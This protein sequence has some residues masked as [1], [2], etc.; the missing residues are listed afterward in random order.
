M[1]SPS[2]C[3]RKSTWAGFRGGASVALCAETHLE[4]VAVPDVC[5]VVRGNAPRMGRG[6]RRFWRCARKRTSAGSRG[7]TFVAV[8]GETSAHSRTAE[9]TRELSSAEVPE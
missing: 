6:A 1:T 9:R 2:C 3:A 7:G 4:W 5:G 8:W